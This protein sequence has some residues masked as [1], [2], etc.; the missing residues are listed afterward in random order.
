[1]IKHEVNHCPRCTAT[2]ECKVGDISNCQCSEVKLSDLTQSFIAKTDFDCLCRNCLLQL[3]QLVRISAQHTFPRQKEFFI[4]GLHFYKEQDN[5][6][7]TELYHLLRGH[8][9]KNGCRH[10]VYGFKKTINT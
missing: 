4:E 10:C 3:N 2:F 5:W 7:F 1:M 8:C 6:V 9:C